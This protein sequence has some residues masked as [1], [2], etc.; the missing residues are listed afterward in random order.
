[1]RLW[2]QSSVF[3]IS[4]LTNNSTTWCCSVWYSDNTVKCSII[5]RLNGK[6]KKKKHVLLNSVPLK[7]PLSLDP[8]L[9]KNGEGTKPVCNAYQFNFSLLIL[10]L[11]HLHSWIIVQSLTWHAINRQLALGCN[12]LGM[13]IMCNDSH[14]STL[15][16]P[17]P[18]IHPISSPLC[19]ALE[20]L[21]TAVPRQRERR[22]DSDFIAFKLSEVPLACLGLLL[23]SSVS[24]WWMQASCCLHPL[25]LVSHRFFNLSARPSPFPSICFSFSFLSVLSH[26]K[27]LLVSHDVG[28]NLF[29]Y[30]MFSFP[31]IIWSALLG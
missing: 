6:T 5:D 13:K 16:V 26:P 7:I 31:L 29:L 24:S 15:S 1:V 22:F 28:S 19:T 21:S 23:Y 25:W 27:Y 3:A 4:L 11:S 17:L 30:V 10:F 12:V 18:H 9:K 14:T 20:T 2:G 8:C